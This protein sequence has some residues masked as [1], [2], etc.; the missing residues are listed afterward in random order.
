MENVKKLFGCWPKN[1]WHISIYPAFWTIV[2]AN[3]DSDKKNAANKIATIA[4]CLAG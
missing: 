2:H 4:N 3:I 1:Y